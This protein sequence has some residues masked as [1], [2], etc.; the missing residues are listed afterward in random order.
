[1]ALHDFWSKFMHT[2]FGPEMQANYNRGCEE[3]NKA[4]TIDI[5]ALVV[6]YVYT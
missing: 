1:M 4:R 3:G 6:F 2:H 5:A